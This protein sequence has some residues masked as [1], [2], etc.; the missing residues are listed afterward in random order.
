M[1][2][3]MSPMKPMRNS[4]VHVPQDMLAGLEQGLREASRRRSQ[5]RRRALVPP[6]HAA[7]TSQRTP[8]PTCPHARKRMDARRLC[9]SEVEAAI[10][11]GR[12]VQARGALM[13]VVGHKEVAAAARA[14]VDLRGVEGV[15][16]VCS[17]YDGTVKTV[18][19]N[20]ALQLSPGAPWRPERP[21]WR[22]CA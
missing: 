13:Y 4:T 11:Y 8:L 10:D 15:H 6:T 9:V 20:R 5:P 12:E 1:S 16:V 19:R 17:S 2:P 7:V 18:Y 14:G 3:M 21:R 22:D